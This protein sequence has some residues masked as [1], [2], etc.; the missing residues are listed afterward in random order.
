[1]HCLTQLLTSHVSAW[2]LVAGGTRYT[3]ASL[4]LNSGSSGSDSSSAALAAAAA[5]EAASCVAAALAISLPATGHRGREPSRIGGARGV[6]SGKAGGAVAGPGRGGAGGC[7]GHAGYS[8]GLQ[9]SPHL[10]QAVPR[11]WGSAGQREAIESGGY[12]GPRPREG[13]CVV[14]ITSGTKPVAMRGENQWRNGLP[15][16]PIPAHHSTLAPCCHLN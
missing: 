9:W 11:S 6:R 1:M 14:V 2:W 8:C 10:C 7:H 4:Q 5:G 12:R 16:G 15:D 3:Y 13:L